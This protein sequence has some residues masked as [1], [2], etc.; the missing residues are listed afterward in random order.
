MSYMW[1]S[2]VEYSSSLTGEPYLYEETRIVVK[3]RILGYT[4]QEIKSNI[5]EYNLFN[6]ESVKQMKR[7]IPVI[8]R[9]IKFLDDYLIDELMNGTKKDSKIV[10]LVL[11]AKNN[12]L[13]HEFV[14]EM[15]ITKVYSNYNVLTKNDIINFF[16]IKQKQSSKVAK[17]KPYVFIKLRQVYLNILLSS[18]FVKKVD[19]V[20]VFDT[21]INKKLL[22]YII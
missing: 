17:W 8:F 4:D 16:E 21:E 6:Y 3:L 13:F 22:D 10:G 14:Q 20:V 12:L 2:V 11:V 18:G 5:I 19:Q 9:R 1:Y 7:I 15:Y